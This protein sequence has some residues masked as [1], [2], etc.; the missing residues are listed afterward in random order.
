MTSFF[1]F[2]LHTKGKTEVDFR[3]S[4]FCFRLHTKRR[5]E[6]RKFDFRFSFR[7]TVFA[8]KEIVF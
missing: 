8:K 7:P 4:V 5:K 6:K 2:R 1:C 3:F